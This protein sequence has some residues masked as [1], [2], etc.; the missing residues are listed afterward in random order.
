MER[1]KEDASCVEQV[2]ISFVPRGR[3]RGK[4]GELMCGVATTST[5]SA[6]GPSREIGI[7]NNF[8]SCTVFNFR[9]N[10]K[11][12]LHGLPIRYTQH[13]RVLRKG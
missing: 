10:L 7:M 4:L 1:E 5:A 6:L 12:E 11:I 3:I 9:H 8:L 2:E 13:T